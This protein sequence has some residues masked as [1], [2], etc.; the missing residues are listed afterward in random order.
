MPT[1]TR[2]YNA[3]LRDLQNIQVTVDEYDDGT[4]AIR[5]GQAALTALRDTVGLGRIAD[6]V[7]PMDAVLGMAINQK[8]APVAGSDANAFTVA[9]VTGVN[10][11]SAVI[12]LQYCSV[13]SVFGLNNASG[14]LEFQISQNGSGFYTLAPTISVTGGTAFA[15]TYTTGARYARLRYSAAA[16]WTTGAS[17]VGTG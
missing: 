13:V 1:I 10:A 6:V 7:P 4:T 9:Q 8:G 2:T 11:T 14:T 15:A 16:T 17:I 3:S 5:A 12:D